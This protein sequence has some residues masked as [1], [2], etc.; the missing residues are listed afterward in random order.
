MNW[1]DIII[2]SILIYRIA[3]GFKLGFVSSILSITRMILSIVLTKKYYPHIY[4]YIN[5]NS[6]I[7]G[8]FHNMVQFILGILFHSKSKEDLN[9]IPNII[10]K[11][12]V[13][14]II[15]FFSIILV[16]WLV[17]ILISIFLGLFSFLR[18][19]PILN[20]LNRIGGLIFGLLEGIFII[21]ILNFLLVPISSV[22]PNTFLGKGILD[23]NILKYVNSI[24]LFRGGL[25]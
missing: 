2:I 23:S 14:L 1:L 22:F 4:G 7:Y 10:S 19:T 5:N 16:F 9:F 8:L 6:K 13:N 18:K 25:I 11:G 15:G 21:Y 12:L 3:K 24:N 17:N 20:Q